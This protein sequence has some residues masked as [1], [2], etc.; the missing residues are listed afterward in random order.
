MYERV[1]KWIIK[2]IILNEILQLYMTTNSE[3][4]SQ[5]NYDVLNISC[6]VNSKLKD[7]FEKYIVMY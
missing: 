2:N 5:K 4:T 7:N 3:K 1:S 6:T